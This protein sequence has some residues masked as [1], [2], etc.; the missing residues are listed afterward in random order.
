M[1]TLDVR[2][3]TL[4]WDNQAP[5]IQIV[6]DRGLSRPLCAGF[7]LAQFKKL[8]LTVYCS[9]IVDSFSGEPR[10]RSGPNQ[11]VDT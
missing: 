6:T 9:P 4:F 10:L 3:N 8:E 2:S 7:E 1:S 5:S 11:L